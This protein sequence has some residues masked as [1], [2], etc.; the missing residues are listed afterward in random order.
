MTILVQNLTNETKQICRFGGTKLF[1]LP[2]NFVTFNCT[3]SAETSFWSKQSIVDNTKNGI[4][5]IIDMTEINTLTKLRN[6]GKLPAIGKVTENTEVISEAEKVEKPVETVNEVVETVETP[7]EI[8]EVKDE[9]DIP[10]FTEEVEAE[11][12]TESLEEVTEDISIYH[13]DDDSNDDGL[14]DM[15]YEDYLQTLTKEELQKEAT[16]K[17]ISFKKNYSAKTL[18]SLLLNNNE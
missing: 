14:D 12:I 7:V 11:P 4:K 3:N 2:N 10:T 8:T 15:S 6:A 18:I 5:V 16:E 1:I 9:A 13:L 17:G